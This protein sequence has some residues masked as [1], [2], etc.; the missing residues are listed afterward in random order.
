MSRRQ[1]THAGISTFT[2]AKALRAS[3][4]WRAKALV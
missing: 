1:D 2:D 4:G 3:A